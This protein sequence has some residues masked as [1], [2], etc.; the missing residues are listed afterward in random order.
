ME[1]LLVGAGLVGLLL[2]G[3]ALVRGAVGVAAR[4]GLPPLVIGLTL[5]GFGTSTP[6]LLTS[7]QAA[8]AGAPGIA[9]GNVVG[10]NSANILL[11]LGLAALLLPIQVTR[12]TFLRDG[13]ALAA[14]T[15]L[16]VVVTLT[17]T[18]GRAW[19]A[20][21]VAGLATFLVVTLRSSRAAPDAPG[22]DLPGLAAPLARSVVLSVVGLAITLGGAKLMVDG[23]VALARGFGVSEALIGVTIVA[24]GTSLPELV[25]TVAA[26]RRGQADVAFGN[27]IGSNIFNILGILGITALIR[28]LA[29]PPEI[30]SFDLW[31]MTA[32][33][34]ALIAF[35][36]T[37]WRITR[38]EGAALLAAY[39]AY[40]GS[41]ILTL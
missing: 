2:G 22:E 3:E 9:I 13:V 34:V 30:A 10:S 16:A 31:V 41:L 14:A 19:G 37:G 1:W 5:V 26:A 39:G 21:L 15:T 40:L 8:L 25:T 18:V 7:V 4:L 38:G 27:V 33:T 12:G 32:A 35:A 20:L 36:V 28:P 23:A 29:V 11:I 6:E 24:I 17:G